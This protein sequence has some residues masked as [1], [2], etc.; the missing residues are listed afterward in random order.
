MRVIFHCFWP[1]VD[2]GEIV[3]QRIG[4]DDGHDD[5]L[6]KL[7]TEREMKAM[8]AKYFR[9]ILEFHANDDN[10]DAILYSTLNASCDNRMKRTYRVSKLDI[11][12][13]CDMLE[14]N[15]ISTYSK[16]HVESLVGKAPDVVTYEMYSQ[17]NVLK[18]NIKKKYKETLRVRLLELDRYK[19]GE[20][21]R[22]CKEENAELKALDKSFKNLMIMD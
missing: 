15:D 6:F 9:N 5:P 7:M 20:I 8:F 17:Y 13:I 1:D 14:E 22:I 3:F 18:N 16:Q 10:D 11:M 2:H 21:D 4:C 19:R 12:L